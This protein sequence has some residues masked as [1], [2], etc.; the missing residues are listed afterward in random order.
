MGQEVEK[1][2]NLKGGFHVPKGCHSKTPGGDVAPCKDVPLG[3]LLVAAV[4]PAG[5][6]T[7]LPASFLSVVPCFP[8]DISGHSW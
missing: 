7:T 1:P 6:V 4:I 2:T 5:A 3:W 8:L